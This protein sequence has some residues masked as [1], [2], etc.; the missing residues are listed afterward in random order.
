MVAKRGDDGRVQHDPTVV[1]KK[2]GSARTIFDI[3][4]GKKHDQEAETVPGKMAGHTEPGGHQKV[5]SGDADKTQLAG[6]IL[7]EKQPDAADQSK[8]E[9]STENSIEPV[10]GWLV[11]V[12]GP[13]RG[14]FVKLGPGMNAVGRDPDERVSIDFGDGEISRKGHAIVTYEPRGKAF[15][16][17]QGSGTNLTYLNDKPVLTPAE[18]SHHDRIGIGKT[19]L[20]FVPFCGPDFDWS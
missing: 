3:A 8:S 19:E 13:G 9:D 16:V 12:D 7:P 15:Y 2:S 14:N 10:V 4:S 6:R 20:V 11:V 18:L 5:K 17:S 1:G